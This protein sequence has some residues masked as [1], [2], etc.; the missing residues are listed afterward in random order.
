[1]NDSVQEELRKEQERKESEELAYQLQIEREI[2]KE[3]T[4]LSIFEM[5]K[6]KYGFE[7]SHRS[8]ALGYWAA[9]RNNQSAC[10]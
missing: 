10:N 4:R 7:V 8:F 5:S 1:M 9:I 3:Y 2:D 6:G